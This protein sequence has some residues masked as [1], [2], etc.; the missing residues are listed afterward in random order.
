MIH[1]PEGYRWETRGRVAVLA[2]KDLFDILS[3]LG[4]FEHGDPLHWRGASGV[5][6]GGRGHAV[7]LSLEGGPTLVVKA[8]LR[9]GLIGVFNPCFHAGPG[10]LFREAALSNHLIQEGVPA[11]PVLLGRAERGPWGGFWRLHLGTEEMEGARTLREIARRALEERSG[12]TRPGKA[13]HEA[14]RVVRKL[15]DAGVFHEDLNL[16]NLLAL[17]EEGR[18]GWK[19]WI[20]DLDRSLAGPPL[21]R[22]PRVAN[23]ARLL[24]HAVKHGVWDLSSFPSLWHR[25]LEGYGGD[26]GEAEALA[27]EVARRF[28][29]SLLLHRLSWWLQGRGDG[30][31]FGR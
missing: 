15:H 28:R 4:I 26:E 25:F 6:H 3:G 11:A 22:A 14:G 20:I 31:D 24:R 9:G 23:L 29:R 18:E 16:G 1:I 5:I 21:E 2:R 30:R 27:R 7:R 10:R 17:P 13:F 19:V 12:L 8:L